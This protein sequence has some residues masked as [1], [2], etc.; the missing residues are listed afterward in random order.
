[1]SGVLCYIDDVIAY[2][3]TAEEHVERL[4]ETLRRIKEA[5]LT[6]HPKKCRFEHM[7]VNYLVFEVAG[8]KLAIQK[9]K[10]AVLDRVAQPND[11]SV[12]RALLGFLYY[13]K[14]VENFSKRAAPLNRL[15]REDLKW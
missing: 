2:R 6:C 4:A 10:V 5:G 11:K 3:A 7:S 9:A 8:G 15:L 12:L 14:F 1:M 13:R